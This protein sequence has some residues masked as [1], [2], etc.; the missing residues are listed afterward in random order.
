MENKFFDNAFDRAK[1]ALE[2]AY[3]KTGEIVTI[4]KLRFNL[5]TLKSKRSK[6]YALLG[7]IYFGKIENSDDLSEKEAELVAALKD[8][9]SKIDETVNEINYL[10][11]KRVCPACGAGIDDKSVYCNFCG[12]KVTFDSDSDTDENL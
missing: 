1:A 4:E 11:A 12:A 3:K 5:T 8:L 9:N 6:N 2:A 10:K 7:K